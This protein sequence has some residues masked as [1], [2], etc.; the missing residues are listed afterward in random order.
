MAPMHENDVERF[1]RWA[2]DYDQARLQRIFFGPVQGAVLDIT[3]SLQPQRLC[4]LDV[5]CGTGALLGR[6]AQRFPEGELHRVDPAPEMVRVVQESTRA[7][8]P[9]SLRPR[10][11]ACPSPTPCGELYAV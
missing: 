4:L 2:V 7:N 3:S 6:A 10:L 5:G 1:N 8:S 9:I 11:R